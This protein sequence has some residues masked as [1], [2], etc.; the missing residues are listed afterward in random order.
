MTCILCVSFL[1]IR[2]NHRAM[3]RLFSILSRGLEI[4]SLSLYLTHTHTPV[5]TSPPKASRAPSSRLLPLCRPIISSLTLVS[6]CSA[7]GVLHTVAGYLLYTSLTFKYV[8]DHHADDVYWC[9]AD[10]GWITGH[11]YIAYG[12]LAN[13]ATSV[14]VS[15]NLWKS[16]TGA[17]K[18]V[19]FCLEN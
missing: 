9:T 16:P 1:I 4:G 8:F 2:T 13:G 14:L 12:P 17:W 15:V 5:C 19:L 3:S 10:I 18:C 6:S 11:S 7:Q